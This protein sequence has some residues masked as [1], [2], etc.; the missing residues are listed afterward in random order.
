MNELY[1]TNLPFGECSTSLFF[2]EGVVLRFYDIDTKATPRSV[3]FLFRSTLFSSLNWEGLVDKH[4][5]LGHMCL[6]NSCTFLL[7]DHN[8]HVV[9]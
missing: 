1:I 4:K 6:R 7:S 5:K 8:V 3:F 2:F 9:C